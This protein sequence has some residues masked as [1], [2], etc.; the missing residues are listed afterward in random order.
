MDL[1][2]EIVR[3]QGLEAIPSRN[4]SIAVPSGKEDA[5]YDLELDLKKQLA[6]LGFFEAN[7]I[8]LISESQLRDAL[9]LRPLQEGDLIKVRLPL[10]E[11]HCMM[12]PSLSPALL[13]AASRNVRQGARQ[14]R[15]FETGRCFRNAG[16]GK[17]RDLENDVIG[18]I[19]GG[20]RIPDSWQN[21]GDELVDSF[22]LKG[23]LSS[24]LPGVEVQLSP[25]DPGNFLLNSQILCNG[26]TIGS[27]AQLSPSRGRELDLDFPVYLAEL[28]LNRVCVL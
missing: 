25:V 18:I 4:L 2:E 16:G 22:D 7:C 5:R 14:I 15:F 27:F 9:P 3:V 12:R 19:L 6:A 1:V 24:I 26:K 10:S 17:A 8:K 11:D 20:Q 13:S 28:D 23:V 21:S